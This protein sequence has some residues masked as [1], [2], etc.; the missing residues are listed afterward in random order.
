MVAKSLY[1][2]QRI[3][4]QSNILRFQKVD[5]I[6][7]LGEVDEKVMRL[8]AS[9]AVTNYSFQGMK[10]SLKLHQEKLSRSLSRLVATGLVGR[11]DGGYAITKKGIRMVGSSVPGVQPIV[12]ATSFL[13]HDVDA[14]SAPMALKG[15][16]FS[17]AR[18]LGS[19]PSGLGTDLKWVSDDGE[20][21]IRVSIR[22]RML[23]VSLA[24]YPP[25]EE[26]RARDLAIRLHGKIMNTLCRNALSQDS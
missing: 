11:A 4:L 16:W 20:T 23:D 8:L 18:W 21:Q 5:P 3:I 15:K 19:S 14:Y 24:S 17:G 13:P 10:R 25:E 6:N 22:D 1:I 9:D 7:S 12:V 26:A 2:T